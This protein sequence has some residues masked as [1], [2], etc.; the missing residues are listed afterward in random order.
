MTLN[1]TTNYL[2]KYPTV[3]TEIDLW[4]QP[5]GDNFPIIDTVLKS[6]ADA[7]A[8]ALSVANSKA[9]ASH[10]HDA[11]AIVSGVLSLTTIPGFVG[12][13]TKP[14]SSAVQTIAAGAVTNAKLA[15]MPVN[16]IK[17]TNV[18]GAPLDLT[19]PQVLA[20]IGGGSVT[21]PDDSITN[22]KLANMAANTIK[23]AVGAGDPADLTATQL[24]AILNGATT[25]LV[26]ARMPA[27]VQKF[28]AVFKFDA[29][30]SVIP[31]GSQDEIYIPFVGTITGWTILTDV[32]GTITFD[33]WG[34]AYASFPPSVA[35]TI[36]G[37]AKPLIG[38]SAR[39]GQSTTLTGWNTTIGATQTLIANIDACAAIKRATLILEIN[40]TT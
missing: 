27:S 21:V 25:P 3:N 39:K 28:C 17:G 5:V 24:M 8:A 31:V 4:G 18:G 36:T 12:D 13:V 38:S 10:T 35:N 37:S 30:A 40:K 9:A 23:G 33:L 32:A 11:G 14:A 7:A 16:T 2:L 15:N 26:I 22:L 6:N 29:G 34:V 1:T 19:G 20:I